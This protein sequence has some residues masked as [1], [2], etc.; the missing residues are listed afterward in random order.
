MTPTTCT[1]CTQVK[2]Q[3]RLKLT[4][5]CW[6]HFVFA[7]HLFKSVMPLLSPPSAWPV[8]IHVLLDNIHALCP[9]PVLL[10]SHCRST[11]KAP[12]ETE[13]LIYRAGQSARDSC[14]CNLIR[15]IVA[16]KNLTIT[17]SKRASS[18][19][20]FSVSFLIQMMWNVVCILLIELF[21]FKNLSRM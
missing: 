7:T 17:F 15:W 11:A 6:T 20:N 5:M 9:A 18:A 19:E 1:K 21:C 2:M 10:A 12:E 3:D 14:M 13:S 16:K 8:S 4:M